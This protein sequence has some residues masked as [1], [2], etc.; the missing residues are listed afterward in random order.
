M[1]DE[2]SKREK[3][4]ARELIAKGLNEDFKIG[5]LEFDAILQ[6]WKNTNG[7][8]G[9]CYHKIFGAVKDFDKFIARRYDNMKGSTYLQI[10][11][12]QL[13]DGLFDAAEIEAF[14]DEAKE[15]ILRWIHVWNMH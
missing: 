1:H 14:G 3:K 5:L 9:D 15:R 11:A 10:V 13:N 12:A 8:N 7:D 2:L 6:E 4:V